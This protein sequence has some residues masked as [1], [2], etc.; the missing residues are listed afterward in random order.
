MV[1]LIA[2]GRRVRL[3]TMIRHQI[4]LGGIQAGT[5]LLKP[6]ISLHFRYVGRF[7]K[8]VSSMSWKIMHQRKADVCHQQTRDLFNYRAKSSEPRSA[9]SAHHSPTGAQ[10]SQ[11]SPAFSTSHAHPPSRYDSIAQPAFQHST[12]S[13]TVHH[14]TNGYSTQPTAIS[15]DRAMPL[16]VSNLDP[17]P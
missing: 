1:H 12:R 7:D 14:D 2:R 11:H 17:Q 5:A 9:N 15:L 10:F 8:L 6:H 4:R 13:P 16:E 3:H